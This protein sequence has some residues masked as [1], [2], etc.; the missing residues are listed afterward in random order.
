MSG[1]YAYWPKV[2]HQDHI[3]PQMASASLQP[4]FF[5]G[6]SQVPI[7]LNVSHGSGFGFHS[8]HIPALDHMKQQNCQG[9]GVGVAYNRH[10]NIMLPKHMSTIKRVI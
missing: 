9:R 6:G 1:N 5:F 7:N 10:H 8:E 3:F 4:P 2:E